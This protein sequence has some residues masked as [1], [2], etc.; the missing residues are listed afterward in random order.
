MAERKSLQVNSVEFD[1][2]KNNLK[3]FLKG[4]ETF[5]DY[6]FEGSGLSVLI[7][8][9]AYNTYYQAFYNNMAVNEMFLDS[10]VKRASVV[11]HA[12]TLGYTPNSRTAP[13]AVVDVTFPSTPSASVLLPGAQFTTSI[14][15][16]TY[17]F[18]NTQT[19]NI[20][21]TAPHIE[22]L[23]IKEG[24]LTT[25]SYVVPD[26]QKNRKYEIPDLSVDISTITVRV[27]ASQTDT[28]GYTDTWSVA[29]NLTE[30]TPTSK[31]Y[32]IEENTLGTFEIVFGDDVLGQKLSAG[33]L[34]TITYLVTNGSAANGA[35]NGDTPNARAFRYL[36]SSYTVEVKSIASG[37][38]EREEI[39][40]IRFKAPRAYSAQNRAVTKGD[41]SS[42]IESNF[43]GFDSVFVYGG[44]EAD[45][46]SFGRVFIA[47]KPSDG[48]LVNETTKKRV[49]DFL[50]TKAVLTITP[51]VIDPD[52]TYLR[53]SANVFYDTTK[54]TLSGQGLSTAIRS[55]IIDNISRNLGKFG[56]V[57]SMS[58]LLTDIDQT[59]DSIESSSV[60]VTM[61][62]RLLPF[63]QRPVSY[64]ANFG[65][66]IYHPHDGH[67]GVTRSNTFKY[68]D[69]VDQQVKNVNIEDDGFGNLSFYTLINETK[70]TV[71]ENAGE[72]D[73]ANGIV[74]LNQVQVLPPDIDP[75][76]VLYAD[77]ENQR[78]KSIRDL[79]LFCD[80][81][82]DPSAIEVTLNGVTDVGSLA[83]SI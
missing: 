77:A 37:G 39:E 71:L 45:P 60:S 42:L 69:P 18:V 66:E 70:Q 62:K 19:V 68:L 30:V 1:G 3:E 47:I 22:N 17:T 36:N 79:I 28:T 7:D 51:V 24:R 83:V 20:S 34:I 27:Q 50:K 65:N 52:Y 8:L 13:T 49:E 74:R 56:T 23:S 63:S 75:Y 6:D 4:Q 26:I 44:E 73:Y 55:S 64:V 81:I 10:A 82:D 12:K 40:D 46:P 29:N 31:V 35:G 59:S 41:Y 38:A 25:T 43:T 9:L 11:S 15:G 53:F 78:Y 21:P 72:V 67:K 2:I 16:R 61:E 80:Y 5:R 14:N 57:F 32:W 58:K 54:T 76:I 48:E 33:N